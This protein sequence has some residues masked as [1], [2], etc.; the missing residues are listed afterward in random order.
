MLEFVVHPDLVH[1]H[2]RFGLCSRQYTQ[3]LHNSNCKHK[4]IEM[5]NNLSQ[6]KINQQLNHT[7]VHKNLM[8]KTIVLKS[9]TMGSRTRDN[10]PILTSKKDTK[11]T[12]KTLPVFMSKFG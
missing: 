8:P 6:R 11:N 1:T 10:G 12:Y 9:K 3:I 4:H 5:P 7:H 2:L